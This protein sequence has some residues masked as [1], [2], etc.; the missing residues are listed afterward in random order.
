[1]YFMSFKSAISKAERMVSDFKPFKYKEINTDINRIY[2]FVQREKAKNPNMGDF[3]IYNLLNTYNSRLKTVS[4]YNEHTLNQ[5]TAYNACLYLLK[6]PRKYD[7]ITAYIE[8]NNLSSDRDFFMHTN[9]FDENL[10][11]LM[12]FMRHLYPQVEAEIKKNYGPIFDGI[13]STDK[14]RQE[15]YSMAEKMLSRLPLMQ[16]KHYLDAFELLL[17]G[18]PAYMRT[19]LDYTE[20]SIRK[21]LIESNSELVSLFDEMGYLDEWLQT[22]NNQFDEIG[23]PELKQDKSAIISGLSP[24]I[25]KTLSTVDLL[26]INI[27][28]TNRALHILNAYSKA[29]YA[30]SEF[31]LEP[32]LLN[33]SEGPQLETED[34]KNVLI[35]MELF[36]YPTEAYYTENET[37]IEELTRSG[38]LIIDDKNSD[39]RYYSM[40]P[41]ET[42]M[43]KSYEK[44]YKEYFSKRLS[45]SKNDVGEDMIRFSQFANAIHRLKSSK[46]RIALSLYSFLELND[47]QKRNYG[48]VVDKISD[49]GTLGEVKHFI[50]FAVDINSILP[51]N[52]HLPKNIFADFAKEYFKEPIVPMYAG[53]NDWDMPNG[54]RIR[55]HIMVPWNKKTKKT[56]KQVSK[57]NN[58]YSQKLVDHFRFLSDENCVPMHFKKTPKDKQIH[59]TYINLDTNSILEKTKE[60]VFI[61]VLPQ[62]QGDDE[63][64]D[65]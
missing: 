55:S 3:N 46:N 48:I 40:E 10:T 26:G 25:Q 43:R 16:K 17:D 19:Y 14:S 9:S 28:Y 38:E 5:V 24:E 36:F 20:S 33:S 41:L 32:L 4:F 51:V 31:N 39:K 58:A 27:M 6:N 29:M 11:N 21:D 1:M 60:G 8:K 37:K 45:A 64:F 63:R 47:C 57:N 7:E 62:V 54:K 42:E 18:M 59:K 13:L 56:I 35:K 65:R 61:K 44:E 2:R 49:D 15:K 53:S 30:I 12:L 34:L 22:A 50:D 23:L 52:V